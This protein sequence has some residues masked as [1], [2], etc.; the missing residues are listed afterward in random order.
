MIM[1]YLACFYSLLLLFNIV[2][3]ALNIQAD[4]NHFWPLDVPKI[5]IMY[6]VIHVIKEIQ[7]LMSLKQHH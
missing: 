2:V 4:I 7:E 3:F 6:N 5:Q 1:P